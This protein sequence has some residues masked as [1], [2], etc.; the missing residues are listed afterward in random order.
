MREQILEILYEV[1]ERIE[2]GIDLIEEGIINSFVIVNIIMELEDAFG[3]EIDAEEV[4]AEN[5]ESV[6]KIIQLVEKMM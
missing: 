2:E 6:E 4:V 3:I 1:D 5:F